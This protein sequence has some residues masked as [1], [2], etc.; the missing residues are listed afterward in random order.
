MTNSYLKGYS[1]PRKGR[2]LSQKERQAEQNRGGTPG[3]DAYTNS[4]EI[5]REKCLMNH[6]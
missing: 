1:V 4:N 2:G 3:P 6:G 5:F